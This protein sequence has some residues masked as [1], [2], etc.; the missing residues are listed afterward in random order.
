MYIKGDIVINKLQQFNFIQIPTCNN[1]T[2]H[3]SIYQECSTNEIS[4]DASQKTCIK[5]VLLET[6]I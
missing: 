3:E 1:H 4:T 6:N 2:T 5:N